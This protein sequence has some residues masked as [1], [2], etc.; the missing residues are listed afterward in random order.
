VTF[1]ARGVRLSI[2][3]DGRGFDVAA[4]LEA[5]GGHWG[6]LGMRERATQVRGKLRVRSTPGQGTEVL[7]LVPYAMRGEAGPRSPAPTSTLSP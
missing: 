4:N 3:D 1:G 2:V 5:F 7:F 6:L